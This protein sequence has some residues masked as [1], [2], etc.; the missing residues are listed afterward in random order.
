M[1]WQEPPAIDLDPT[2]DAHVIGRVTSVQFGIAVL[3]F[4]PG[5]IVLSTLSP[6][7][8]MVRLI[9]ALLFPVGTFIYYFFDGPRTL[10]IFKHY[11]K[12]K[13]N[14]P[15][16]DSLTGAYNLE[17]FSTTNPLLQVEEYVLV[18]AS[19]TLQPVALMGRDSEDRLHVAME[20]LIRATAKADV[21][22]DWFFSHELYR[23]TVMPESDEVLRSRNKYWMTTGSNRFVTQLVVRLAAKTQ[24]LDQAWIQAEKVRR[25]YES[26]GGEGWQWASCQF[27][28]Q[29]S[30]D[31]LDPGAAWRRYIDQFNHWE[32]G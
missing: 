16:G 29:M 6:W 18:Y 30:I 14:I 1:H 9:V 15:P 22:C 31:Q 19:I 2:I 8:F 28:G 20:R 4:V 25:G 13:R 5:L 11:H 12:R 21:I 32:V 26:A 27:V 7:S 3:S 24:D 10:A 23:P 17:D